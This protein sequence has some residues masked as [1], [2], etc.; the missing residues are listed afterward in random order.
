MGRTW[1]KLHSVV[2]F[3]R[4]YNSFYEENQKCKTIKTQSI[5]SYQLIKLDTYDSIK[6]PL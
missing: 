3:V 6:S 5:E 1:E 4:K 2:I